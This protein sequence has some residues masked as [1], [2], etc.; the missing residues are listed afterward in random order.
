MALAVI[1]IASPTGAD[2]NFT[3]TLEITP[4]SDP[5]LGANADITLTTTVASPQQILALYSLELPVNDNGTPGDATDDALWNIAGDG[6]VPDNY[7]T[8]VGTIDVDQGLPGDVDCDSSIEHFDFNLRDEFPDDEDGWAQWGGTIAGFWTLELGVSGSPL[9]N[10]NGTPTDPSDDFIPGFTI[11]GLLTDAV[12][13]NLCTPEDVTITFC[14]R[15][16]PDPAALVCGSGTDPIVMT[17]PTIE[18]TYTWQA[19]FISDLGLGA[20]DSDAVCI[21]DSPCSTD[22]DG[23]GV[24]DDIDNCPAVPN[25][26][27][28]A[29]IPNVGNQTDS[30]GDGEGDACDL[31]DDNDSLG[32][33]LI[34]SSGACP[35]GGLSLPT[36]RDCIEQFLGTLQDEHCADTEDI[37]D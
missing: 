10:D 11:E 20:T 24:A 36:F 8:A 7:V 37:D 5:G 30:D 17:N 27:A 6:D 35:T 26:L 29:G 21:S 4:M 25:G 33:T 15:A 19:T 34:D 18:A 13:V 28:E 14:G 32:F 31:D 3:P 22:V 12:G 9:V 23:D 16:N 1:F 2:P